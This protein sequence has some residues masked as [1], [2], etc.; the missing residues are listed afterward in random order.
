[1][2]A[3]TMRLLPLS[4]VA[5]SACATGV[6]ILGAGDVAT[7]APR[8]EV[9][10]R[11]RGDGD[12]AGQGAVPA[13]AANGSASASAHSVAT[14]A[15]VAASTSTTTAILHGHNDYLQPAPLQRA[16]ALGLGSVEAD[17]FLVD[18]ELRVGHER[19]QLRA[20]RT[21]R[22]LYLE[23]LRAHVAAHGSASL[24]RDPLRPFVLLVDIKADGDAVYR[25]LR[26][27]LAD[28]AP[29]LTRFVD[30][31][32]ERNAVT[33]V[34]SGSR[35]RALLA[36]ERDRW[37][38]LDGR[39]PDL[40]AVPPPPA[41]LVPWISD[42]WSRVSDWT[43]TDELTAAERARLAGLAARARAQ[44]RE[45]RFWG[46][47]DRPEAWQALRDLGIARI[48]TD[49]PTQAARW[50]LGAGDAPQ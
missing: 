50:A 35:P 40:D 38:A 48:G 1:M 41:D 30:G 2:A 20:S 47:P 22:A 29:M 11:E 4:L 39:L 18:G 19:W 9:A 17:V 5:V 23:P 33:V 45:L 42:A 14:S 6:S 34:L 25:A 46:A 13:A 10:A 26:A 43:G 21:L 31:R 28:F 16:L 15:A 27:E 32:V 44:G 36:A 3:K 8:S 49:R 24:S 37:C 7:G 12:D